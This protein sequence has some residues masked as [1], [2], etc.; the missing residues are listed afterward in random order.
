MTVSDLW[1]PVVAVARLVGLWTLMCQTSDISLLANPTTHEH[2]C[3]G[4][5]EHAIDADR[6][7]PSSVCNAL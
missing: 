3:L 2:S 6:Q 7:C 1:E 5:Y 4:V